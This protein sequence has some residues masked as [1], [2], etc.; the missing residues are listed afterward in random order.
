MGIGEMSRKHAEAQ[1]EFLTRSAGFV[2]WFSVKR[3]PRL[4]ALLGVQVAPESD[5]K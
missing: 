5:E 3:L 1:T 2:Y 4:S